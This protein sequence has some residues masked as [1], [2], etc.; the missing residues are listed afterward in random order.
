MRT[1]LVT[2][3]ALSLMTIQPLQ[4]DWLDKQ[5]F[6]IAPYVQLHGPVQGT[7]LTDQYNT[8]IFRIILEEA[9]DKAREYLQVQDYEGYWAFIIG[10][11][12]VPLHEGSNLHFRKRDNNGRLCQ[13]RSNSGAIFSGS[14]KYSKTFK[15]IFKDLQPTAVPDC[16]DFRDDPLVQQMLHGHD[17]SDLGIMQVNLYWHERNYLATGDW[18]SV[19]KSVRYGLGLYKTGFDGV[20]R[21]SNRYSCVNSN[22]GVSYYNLIRAGWSGVYNSGNLGASC[23]FANP[24]SDWA[25]NDIN[26]KKSLDKILGLDDS[27]QRARSYKMA[28][29]E[30]ALLEQIVQHYKNKTASAKI[31]TDYLVNRSV[32]GTDMVNPLLDDSGGVVV[33][34]TPTPTPRPEPAPVVLPP[35]V[36]FNPPRIYSVTAS[37][38]NFRD[39]PNT[40]YND[41]G[42]LPKNS[43]VIVKAQQ[44]DWMVLVADEMLASYY[45][46]DSKC[47][48]GDRFAHK[49]FLADK[50][51]LYDDPP[52]DEPQT[53]GP[54]PVVVVPT[55]TPTPAPTPTPVVN[56]EPQHV[57]RIVGRVKDWVN[58]R[59]DRPHGYTMAPPTGDV[60]GPAG[61][62]VIVAET[63]WNSSNSKYPW[64]R[65]TS[66][67]H[68]WI[69]GQYVE[70]EGGN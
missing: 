41:C 1:K 23:R 40:S 27:V 7:M 59:E 62:E 11:L 47:A 34:P 46:S 61:A 31:L 33:T 43:E 66:P 37:I 63:I 50:G 29:F 17:G 58:V 54:T 60:V 44:G 56:E 15:R 24:N 20:Y 69:Y 52:I 45:A 14:S 21:N 38:L 49:S 68:G 19:R 28:A 65:I 9:H 70:I 39:G 67:V 10:A 2:T 57:Q 18:K 12:T 30:D 26:F 5:M 6:T 25:Q 35:R 22:G 42:D 48:R 4:A 64:Y 53:D 8:K 55:P 16:Y 51:P 13:E 32:E 36:E 3:L